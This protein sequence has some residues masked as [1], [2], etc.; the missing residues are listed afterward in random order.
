MS[1]KTVYGRQ[2]RRCMPGGFTNNVRPPEAL[3]H[4]GR[5]KETIRAAR[6]ALARLSGQTTYAPRVTASSETSPSALP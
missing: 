4:L 2:T 3:D 1:N 5:S 6:N